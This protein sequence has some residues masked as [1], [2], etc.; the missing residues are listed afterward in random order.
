MNSDYAA[1]FVY[2]YTTG[3]LATYTRTTLKELT[4]RLLHVIVQ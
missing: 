1:A 3:I 2:L 4:K